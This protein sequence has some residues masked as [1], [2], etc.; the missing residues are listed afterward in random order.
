MAKLVIVNRDITERKRA[1]EQLKHNLFHDPR[2][3]LSK[4]KA[5][6]RPP[7]KALFSERETQ[8]GSTR[9]CS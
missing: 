9:S 4:P 8:H 1:E 6:S 3:N 7:N 2:T 5:L